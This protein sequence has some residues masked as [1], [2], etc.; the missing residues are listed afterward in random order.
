MAK[1]M[2]ALAK[3]TDPR[4]RLMVE[5]LARTGMRVGELAAFEDDA[6]VQ[7][8]ETYWLR[9]PVGKLHNDRYVPLHPI[10]VDLITDYRDRRGPSR[11]VDSS[12]AT[13]A[14]P[15]TGARSTAT[16]RRSPSGPASATSTP[17]SSA[18]PSP[19]RPSTGA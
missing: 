16:S 13:T 1:F 2:A 6:M 17:T 12:S 10:L 4:R 11:R 7:I 14:I 19:P 5:L 9:I 18:I 8:S 3:D 15:S